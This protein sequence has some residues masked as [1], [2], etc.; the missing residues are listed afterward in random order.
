MIYCENLTTKPF[1]FDDDGTKY[2]ETGLWAGESQLSNG[3]ESVE[4]RT[5][6][7]EPFGMYL[8]ARRDDWY[9][10][11]IV[12]L[13]EVMFWLPVLPQVN[14]RFVHR[15][16]IFTDFNRV[17]CFPLFAWESV[18]R[19]CNVPPVEFFEPALRSDLATLWILSLPDLYC[20]PNHADLMDQLYVKN[21]SDLRELLRKQ[22]VASEIMDLDKAQQVLAERI[23]WLEADPH[24]PLQGRIVRTEDSKL[25]LNTLYFN[26]EEV[27]EWS[28]FSFDNPRSFTLGEGWLYVE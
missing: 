22:L 27:A 6:Q 11:R 25:T 16:P 26:T 7:I 20:R 18:R 28:A 1:E 17:V 3:L 5:D 12:R 4:W 13:N 15:V 21:L 19:V 24:E 8:W 10:S 9:A 14:W 2:H 23:N